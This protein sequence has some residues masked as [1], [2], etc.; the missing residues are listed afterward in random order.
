MLGSS[1]RSGDP[2]TTTGPTGIGS[3]EQKRG[4]RQTRRLG[5]FLFLIFPGG[6]DVQLLC[7]GGLLISLVVFLNMRLRS[8]LRGVRLRPLRLRLIGFCGSSTG[9]TGLSGRRRLRGGGG[10]GD[11]AAA[12]SGHRRSDRRVGRLGASFAVGLV[13]TR[14]CHGADGAHR[15]H[16]ARLLGSG[17]LGGG[18]GGGG[19]L[20]ATARSRGAHGVGGSLVLLV[21]FC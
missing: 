4:G 1:C 14:R 11:L 2:P 3:L 12:T 20:T 5:Y 9:K 10:G 21:R 18:G 19:D 15:T 7:T 13:R 17:S 16:R 6:I 8:I